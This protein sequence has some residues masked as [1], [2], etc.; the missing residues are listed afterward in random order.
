MSGWQILAWVAIAA[1]TVL[2]VSL[3][4]GMIV[5]IVFVVRGL[6]HG[7]PASSAS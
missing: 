1:I 3:L 6:I 5:V 7:R 2:R 4:V